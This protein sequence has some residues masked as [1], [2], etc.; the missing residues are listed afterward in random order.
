MHV[1]YSGVTGKLRANP[2]FVYPRCSC[3]ACPI[4]RHP[5]KEVVVYDEALDVVDEFC[6]LGISFSYGCGC[7]NAIINTYRVPLG[8]SHLGTSSTLL[9]G[10]KTWAPYDHLQRN[11]KAMLHSICGVK[12]MGGISSEDLLAKLHLFDATVK[13]NTAN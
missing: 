10:D 6:Y 3:F 5:V 11:D 2:E 7:T 8:N 13:L 4:D 12:A 1:R 9:Y